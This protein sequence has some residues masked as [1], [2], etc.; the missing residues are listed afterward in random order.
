MLIT[1]EIYCTTGTKIEPKIMSVRGKPDIVEHV[2]VQPED[3]IYKPFRLYVNDELM[4][5]RDY[6]IPSSLIIGWRY[7][8]ELNLHQGNNNI[9][10]ESLDN[11]KYEIFK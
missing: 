1:C 8:A 4:T 2:V 10:I 11:N 9:R 7:S 3:R 6:V 5:E